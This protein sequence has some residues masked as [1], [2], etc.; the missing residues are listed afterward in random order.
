M[1]KKWGAA[2]GACL[3]LLMAA[4]GAV[5]FHVQEFGRTPSGPASEEQSFTVE[6]G[7]SVSAMAGELERRGLV[8]SAL[9]FRLFAR[10]QGYDRRLKAGEYGLKASMT[11]LEMLVLMEK[12][13]V[14]LHRLTVPEGLTIPQVAAVVEKTG[15]ARAA[16]I[17]ARATDPAYAGL[18]G[19][20]AATLEGYL[21]PET[22]LFPKSVTVDGILGAMLQ[23]FRSTF[24]PDWE[25]RAME[26]GLTPHEAVTL[27]SI[28]EKETGDP[29]ERPLIASVFHNRL[30]RGMRLETDPAVIYGIKEF[31]GN[32]TRKHLET[33]G[34]YNTY[35]I[36]G[37][38]PGPI[39]SPGKK[40]IEAALFP[41]QTD[42]LF[43]VSK[44]NGSHQFSS[45]LTD[46]NRAVQYYQLGPGRSSGS[47][48]KPK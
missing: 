27:A 22:Y 20:P 6:P 19:I 31:D 29:S 13:L 1:A 44:N 10:M 25:R 4:A 48:H 17:M 5:Y 45:N 32:L 30:K 14:R 37:L 12:G 9:K 8:S 7:R 18:Q 35:L 28:I 39:A 2:A 42:Y 36:K 21:F 34:P 43:F 23:R 24:S 41:A 38:P 11:P 15:L 47:D 3:L 16:D 40:A 33:P 26:I 46:H